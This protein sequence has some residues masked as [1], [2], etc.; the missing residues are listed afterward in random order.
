[1]LMPLFKSTITKCLIFTPDFARRVHL[2]R[3]ELNADPWLFY[4]WLYMVIEYK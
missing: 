3:Y 2:K 1:M 4:T